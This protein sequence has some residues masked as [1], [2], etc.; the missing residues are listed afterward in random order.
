MKKEYDEMTARDID[1][2]AAELEF[3]R[4]AYLDDLIMEQF[5]EDMWEQQPW[6]LIDEK[7]ILKCRK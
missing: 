2:Y 6:E 3:R 4:D 7:E 5:E 1:N